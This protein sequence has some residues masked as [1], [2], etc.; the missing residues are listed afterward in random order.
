M[1]KRLNKWYKKNTGY[2]IGTAGILAGLLFI[3][4]PETVPNWI[5]IMW[6]IYFIA[7]G[8]ISL[9]DN[10]LDMNIEIDPFD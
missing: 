7:N 6:G 2:I 3:I 10:Y 1:F 8:L 9:A 4:L 5:I